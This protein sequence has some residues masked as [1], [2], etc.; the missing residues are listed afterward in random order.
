MGFLKVLQKAGLVELDND[1]VPVEAVVSRSNL[2]AEP[3]PAPPPP[4]PEVLPAAACA[5]EEQRSFEAMYHQQGVPPS[6]FPAEKLL[7][8]LEGLRA[9]EPA[10][11][12]AA[13]QAMDAADDAWTVDDAV[14]DAQRKIGALQQAQAYLVQQTQSAQAHAQEQLQQREQQ[15]LAAVEAIKRQLSELEGLREREVEKATG[16]RVAIQA[17]AQ[18]VA[19]ASDRETARL[20]GEV[21][22]LLQ[23]IETFGTTTPHTAAR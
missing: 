12:K 4:A 21:A 2:V 11:R 15:H 1:P 7:K 3:M 14:L 16:D 18:A 20:E 9:M 13:I 8:L 17:Q 5:I 6:P 23:I 19:D 22:R 10:V